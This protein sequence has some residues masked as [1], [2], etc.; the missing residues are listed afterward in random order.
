MLYESTD[1][2][3]TLTM[4]DGKVN[5][6]SLG[7][8]EAL[9][10]ALDRAESDNA[11]VVLT[12]RPGVFS[13]GFDLN[14]LRAGGADAQAMVIGGFELSERLLSFPY[15]VVVACT[16]HAI[17]MGLFL[18][19]SGDF[20]VGPEG[21]F[22][23]QANEVAIGLTMP[24][25]AIEVLRQRMSPGCFPRAVTLAETFTPANAVA[26]G[27]LD[28]VVPT[29]QVAARA[30]QVAAM[31]STLDTAAHQHSK[32]RVRRSALD[33]LR[34]GIEADKAELTSMNN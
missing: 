18:L 21:P 8:Q 5:V 14:T 3:A 26:A 6:M 29:S 32:L 31:A 11:V 2:I 24:R 33:A 20:R 16:G 12:G 30:Q 4:D 9:H 17:A 10:S 25:A 19:L 1:R 23:F 34:I 7:M 28:E 15:P 13:A 27:I 22:K